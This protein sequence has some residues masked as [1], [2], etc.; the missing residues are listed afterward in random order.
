M[1]QSFEGEEA[2]DDNSGPSAE[3]KGCIQGVIEHNSQLTC[4][5]QT[6][7]IYLPVPDLVL[8]RDNELFQVK[9]ENEG[10]YPELY[11]S[12][13]TGTSTDIPDPLA[14][15]DLSDPLT[16][17]CSSVKNDEISDDEEGYVVN[18]C[19]DA[20]TSKQMHQDSSNQPITLTASQGEKVETQGTGAMVE[21]VEWT[22][23]EAKK[24]PSLEENAQ[25]IQGGDA[26]DDELGTP[27]DTKD[28][29]QD[30]MQGTSH[31]TCSVQ[32]TEIYIPVE[33]SQQPGGNMLVTVKEENEDPL[34]EGKYPVV[35]T[36]NPD[37]ISSNAIDPLATDDVPTVT[38]NGELIL[39]CTMA[40]ESMTEAVGECSSVLEYISSQK[41]LVIISDKGVLKNR[42]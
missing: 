27:A 19:S 6:T 29:I 36:P 10:N 14:G 38:E 35:K 22:L 18:D 9:D 5:T 28:F 4:S 34:S 41:R 8:P 13:P 2:A 16:Y 32:R 12:D 31:L 7:E 33:D 42:I 40:M 24:E 1:K 23:I 37:G 15:D 17:K 21:D 3:T 39:N 30:V 25:S 20:A 11:T 26:A